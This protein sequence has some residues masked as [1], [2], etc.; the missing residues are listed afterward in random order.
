M[1]ILY[2]LDDLK[3]L[4]PVD[5]SA[6]RWL[7]VGDFALFAE[8]LRLC[9]QKP[10]SREKWEAICA[11]GVRY[12]GCFEGDKMVARACVEP[13]NE[14]VWET[15]DVRP[16][17]AWRGRG[18]ATAACAFAT[19]DTLGQGRFATVR[20]EADNLRMRW[21]IARLGFH[22]LGP[23]DRIDLSSICERQI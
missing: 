5:T 16:A 18:C 15:A 17:A 10:L 21:V 4:P 3:R 20:T 22:E 13:L 14:R 2:L 19:R 8:H 1:E 7:E 23:A 9:G 6:V 11:A 12:C